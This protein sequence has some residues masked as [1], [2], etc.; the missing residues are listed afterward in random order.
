MRKN[1][2]VR[3]VYGEVIDADDLENRDLIRKM[4]SE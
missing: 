3:S 4:I 2:K 1:A